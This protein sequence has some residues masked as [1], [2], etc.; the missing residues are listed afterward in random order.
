MNVIRSYKFRLYPNKAQA[1]EMQSHLWLSKEL[2][3]EMLE[4]TID[5]YC[6]H[7]KFPTT[8]SLREIVK[9][10]GLYSQTGQELVD[11]LGDALRKKIRMKKLGE[12]GGFPRFKGLDRMKSLAYPQSGFSL[13]DRKLK[14]TPFGEINIKKHREIHGAIKTLALKRES[15]D[16]WFA[17]LTAEAEVRPVPLKEGEAVGVD[18][19]LMTFASISNGERIKKPGHMRIYEEKLARAQRELSNK[20]LHSK[21][22]RKAKSIIG[23]VY[24]KVADTRRDWLHKAANLLLSRYSMVAF[25]D[26]KVKG[27]AEEHGKGVNDA[28]WSIFTDIL[29]YKAEDAGCEVV[30]VDPKNTSKDC[31][32]CGTCVPKELWE[33]QHDCPSCGLSMDRDLNAAINILMRATGGTSGSN[34]CGDVSIETSMKQEAHGFSHG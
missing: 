15:S 10:S 23:K 3:N 22:R 27:I 26:L 5:I 16:K 21:N 9:N 33:R 30:F 34:A 11:R 12:K 8:R 7:Q 18:L 17:I 4:F 6:N 20:K 13:S 32:R 29:R 1:K 2:W 14:V 31:S 28:G 24:R 25:E 19:G